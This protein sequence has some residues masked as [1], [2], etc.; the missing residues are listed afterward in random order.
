MKLSRLKPK[1]LIN[2]EHTDKVFSGDDVYSYEN[3]LVGDDPKMDKSYEIFGREFAPGTWITTIHF[4]N[5]Q[6]FEDFVLSNK[7]AGISLEGLFEQIPFNFLKE[8]NFVYPNAGESE[9]DFVSRCMG[10]SKMVSEFPDEAQRAAVCYSYY[11]EKMGDYD[12]NDDKE[13]VDG[14]VDLLLKVKDL[15][16]RKEIA[17]AV[18]KDFALQG[19]E[20]DYDDFLR[21]IQIMDFGFN[22]PEGTCWEGYEPYGTKILDG[23]E[24]PNCVPIRTSKEGF[25]PYPWNECIK[26]QLDAG[27]SEDVAQKICGKIRSE[28]M[29]LQGI[30]GKVPYFDLQEEAEMMAEKIGCDGSHKMDYGFVPCRTHAEAEESWDAYTR[31]FLLEELI[32]K[33]M[34]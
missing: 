10:D 12:D 30:N 7:T 18:I 34:G 2:F 1:N 26:D 14:I 6:L 29:G 27:Y 20:Y 28:N 22:V 4:R 5:R 23:R 24:V 32:K 17:K 33:V 8:E 13:M 15:E 19:V 31:V 16:N 25:A 9:S 21:R 3:W 11:K